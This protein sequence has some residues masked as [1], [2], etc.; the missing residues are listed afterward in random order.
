MQESCRD[1]CNRGEQCTVPEYEVQDMNTKTFHVGLFGKLWREALQPRDYSLQSEEEEENGEAEDPLVSEE[2]SCNMDTA[3]ELR[4]VCSINTLKYEGEDEAEPENIPEDTELV[5]LG[6]R[7]KMQERR[8]ETIIVDRIC[9][10][11]KFNY[12]WESHA[13]GKKPE[14]PS[15]LVQEGELILTFNIIYPIIFEKHKEHKPYQRVLVL[16]SQNLTELRDFIACVSDLQVGG[17]YSDTPDMVPANISKD[18][19][20]SAFFYFNGVFYNDMRYPECRDLS[21]TVIDWSESLDRGYGKFKTAQMEHHTF[22]DLNIK[23]GFPYFYCHQ[24]D[25]EHLVLITDIRL[26]HK[27]DCLDRTLYPLITKKPWI[28]TRKCFVCK[29]YI[30]RW[31]T[32]EDSLAPED[33]CL[34]CDVCFRMLHYDEEGNKLGEF[35]CYPYLDPGTFN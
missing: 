24:G 28:L 13:D 34:F 25:C 35:L 27:D 30:A 33:P 26:V 31:V 2:L 5:T 4:L 11:E 22:N 29:M 23:V 18:L 3:A 12:A 1:E 8:D 7:K 16:G 14:N 10:Q 17:E 6:I 19:F 32:N 15:N 9:R 21:K 20:K